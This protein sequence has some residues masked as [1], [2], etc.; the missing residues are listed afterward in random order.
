MVGCVT[1]RKNSI[2]DEKTGSVTHR[3]SSVVRESY[4]NIVITKEFVQQAVA[5]IVRLGMLQQQNACT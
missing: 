5:Q 2:F 3:H 1:Q 4:S